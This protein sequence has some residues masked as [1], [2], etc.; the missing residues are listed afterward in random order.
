MRAFHHLRAVAAQFD[1]KVAEL[2]ARDDVMHPPSGWVHV[3]LWW[4]ADD[5]IGDD[6]I[7]TAQMIGAARDTVAPEYWPLLEA[8]FRA[9]AAPRQA[10]RPAAAP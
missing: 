4:R 2:R 10:K 5:P 1:A 3:R 7:A 8:Y 6:Y 9:L